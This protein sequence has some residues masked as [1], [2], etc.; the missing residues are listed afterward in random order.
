MAIIV[1]SHCR[2]REARHQTA[3]NI[4]GRLVYMN[5]C[6]QC[7]DEISEE[8]QGTESL[9]Q[10][11][12]DLTLYAKD[13]KLDPVIGRDLEIDRVVHILSRRKKN[14]PVLIG[15]PGVG[16]TAIVEGLAQKLYDNTVPEPLRNKRLVALDLASM[17]AGTPHRGA[18]EKRLKE[19]IEEVIKTKGQ[20]ILF[21]DEVHTIVGAGSAQGSMDAANILKPYLARGEL[22]LIGATTLKEYRI[23]EKDAALERRFQ[24]IQVDEPS[25]EHTLR[26]LKGLKPN[27][28]DHHKINITLESMEAA[29]RLSA[30]YIS[31]KFL[32]DKAI[33]L[34][35]EAGAALRLQLAA[36]EPENLREV[37]SQIKSLEDKISEEED[38]LQKEK[39]ISELESLR[40]VK[41]ELADL[42]V[43]TK[44]EKTPTLKEEHVAAVV[45]SST[46]IPISELSK[47]ER[48]KLKNMEST[49]KEFI[50]AQDEAI[51]IISQSVK[52]ARAGV[53]PGS[54][55]IGV[56]MFL[57][58]TGVGKTELAKALARTLYGSDDNLIRV[59]MSEFNERHNVSRLIGAPPGYIG[60]EEGGQLTEKVRRKPFS[61]IL[62]DE[63]EKAHPEVFNTLLQ[64]MDEGRFTDGQG[65]TVDFKNTVIIMTSNVGSEY[66]KHQNIGFSNINEETKAKDKDAEVEDAYTRISGRI[67][68]A[69][70]NQFKPEFLNRL[71]DVITFRPLSRKNVENIVDIQIKEFAENMNEN[72]IKINIT[73]KAK[74]YLAENGYSLEMGA[75]PLK[76]LIQKE[77]ENQISEMI[78]NEEIKKGD[79]V[80]LDATKEG[81]KV[82]VTVDDFAQIG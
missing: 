18:F 28:E 40:R 74:R 52:R 11:S 22:Q 8:S 78:I 24:I 4:N 38:E 34:I 20:V 15:E 13:G 75:R 43:Q 77:I 67:K 19:V 62:F 42:W 21:I 31:D 5:L 58:P 46:G 79:V 80:H 17:I 54:R 56:F 44:L 64:V 63:I 1:E 71:D 26:I 47:D 39:Y 30:R 65:R 69:L 10:F 53:R 35:D 37:L 36:E 66:L 49:M 55:P 82:K 76:R 9:N 81:I 7:F 6:D 68:D 61:V 57:G 3:M 29:V 70:H 32:P 33:D 72:E 12:K 48:A 2:K 51:T 41:K 50:V 14:N 73:K 60:Y 59:D 23:V 25:I 27:Y 16:K 45:A